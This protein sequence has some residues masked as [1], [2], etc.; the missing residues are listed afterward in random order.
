M[1]VGGRETRAGIHQDL[2]FAGVD[3]Q[4]CIGTG[5][6]IRGKVALIELLL[7]TIR[8]NVGHKCIGG[9]V[10][11]AVAH[12]RTF[13]R[14]NLEPVAVSTHGYPPL[15]TDALA[16]VRTK[17]QFAGLA[18]ASFPRRWPVKPAYG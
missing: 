10:E 9:V 2:M 13:E 12:T 11:G 1:A 16:D 18:I 14:T 17:T 3:Q 7:K 15:H 5:Y 6:V 4:T 8:R